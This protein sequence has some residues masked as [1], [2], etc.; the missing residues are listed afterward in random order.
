MPSL[1][2]GRRRR[3]RRPRHGAFGARFINLIADQRARQRT[4]RTADERACAC[5]MALVPDDGARARA[6]RPADHGPLLHGR[7]L[8]SGKNHRRQG[9]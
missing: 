5:V 2:H 6:Q 3:W 4:S 8:A 1:D 9:A 7:R